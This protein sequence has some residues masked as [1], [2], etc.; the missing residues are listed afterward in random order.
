MPKAL[1]IGVAGFVGDYL[2]EQLQFEG[3]NVYATKSQKGRYEREGVA[4]YDLDILEYTKVMETI[5]GV[6]PNLIFNL[7]AQSSVALSWQNPQ[8][9]VDVNIK[10]TVN[11][12][13]AVKVSG[14]LPRIMLI[15]SGEEYGCSLSEH[16]PVS[17][18]VFPKPASIYAI[19]KATQNMLGEL[20]SK[21][22][23]MEIVSVRAFNHIGPRQSAHFVISD[24]CKQVAEIENGLRAPVIYVGNLDAKRDFTDVRDIVRAYC[25]LAKSGQTGVTYNV[26]SGKSISIQKILEIILNLSSA[27]IQVVVDER[28]LRPTDIP[29]VEADI[30]K[31]RG[32][33]W[34]PE[35][36]IHE[37][38][39][40]ILDYW[41]KE[42]GVS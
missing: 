11:L 22:Y 3:Y 26:G 33:N 7:A 9:T 15:G 23:N 18:S 17:E 29:I 6:S 8:L 42:I 21:V 32:M 39:T 34:A 35:I 19:T 13:E 41:R 14:L 5:I 12:L 28:K 25:V 37:S 20:Y 36:D 24:F 38:L 2:A 30:A 4:V 1:I 27:K 31:V 16:C 40:N 10:G